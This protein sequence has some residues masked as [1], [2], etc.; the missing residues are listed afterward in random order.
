MTDAMPVPKDSGPVWS[1]TTTTAP[2]EGPE[3]TKD[4][5]MAFAKQIMEL[6]AG[7]HREADRLWGNYRATGNDEERADIVKLVRQ[8]MYPAETVEAAK[9][10]LEELKY[11]D[12]HNSQGN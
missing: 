9:N 1:M 12:L 7:V 8:L 11:W 2:Y 6:T 10:K 5:Q 3:M 4:R